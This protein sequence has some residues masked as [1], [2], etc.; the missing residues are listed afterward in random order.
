MQSGKAKVISFVSGKGGVGK[1][2]LLSEVAV[3]LAQRGKRI[4]IIDGDMGL[5]NI[6]VLFGVRAKGHIAQVINETKSLQDII[7]SLSPRVDLISSGSGIRSLHQLGTLERQGLITSLLDLQ[8]VY[9]YVLID[10]SSGLSEFSF[11]LAA[12]SDV[13]INVLTS[14]PSSFTDSYAIIK[15]LNQDFKR[16]QFYIVTNQVEDEASG[17]LLFKKFTEVTGRFLILSLDYLGSVTFDSSVKKGLHAQKLPIRQSPQSTHALQIGKI[18]DNLDQQVL[19]LG[20]MS[21]FWTEL[22]GVA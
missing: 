1:S 22:S 10:T 16:E 12:L 3:L 9:D 18:V 15:S 7:T 11:Q 20:N 14:D 17:A 5:A 21:H 13:V 6:D 2:L 8:Y 4:L 19:R